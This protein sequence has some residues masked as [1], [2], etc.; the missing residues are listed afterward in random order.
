MRMFIEFEGE[1]QEYFTSRKGQ[2]YVSV[3]DGD[4]IGVVFSDSFQLIYTSKFCTIIFVP[5]CFLL[6]DILLPQQS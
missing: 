5:K 2:I 1:Q 4:V 6:L 3:D